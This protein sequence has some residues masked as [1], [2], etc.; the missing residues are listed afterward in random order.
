MTRLAIA[1]VCIPL[2][3]QIAATGL[4][5]SLD[6]PNHV[7]RLAYFATQLGLGTGLPR[8]SPELVF[9]LGYPLF[10]YYAPL[11]YYLGS[12]IMAFGVEAV[13]AFR[14]V[15]VGV[16]VLAGL[17]MFQLAVDFLRP[18]DEGPDPLGPAI[19]SATAYVFAPYFVVNLYVRVA[20]AELFAMALLPWVLWSFRRLVRDAQPA[21]AWPWAVL[22][23]TLLVF[24][25]SITIL[26]APTVIAAYLVVLLSHQPRRWSWVATA[27]VAAAGL[28]AGLWLPLAL[29]RG[30]VSTG[31]LA[32]SREWLDL[33][34]LAGWDQLNPFWPYRYHLNSPFQMGVFQVGL[35]VAG[36]LALKTKT[37]EARYLAW[38]AL[39]AWVLQWEVLRPL[40][41]TSDIWTIIQF[42]WRLNLL[43]SLS[44]A[45]LTGA[46]GQR[47]AGR[48]WAA[49][50]TSGLVLW[51]VIS[52]LPVVPFVS[53][54]RESQTH[55][56][57]ANIALYESATTQIGLSANVRNVNSDFIPRWVDL[58]R[59]LFA[60]AAAEPD[61]VQPEAI[62]VLTGSVGVMA[63]EVD[64]DSPVRIRSA[65]FYFPGWTATT[66]QGGALSVSAEPGTGWLAVD[67]PAGVTRVTLAYTG[68]DAQ[69]WAGWFSVFTAAVLVLLAAW[70]R[71]GW[72][73]W[74]TPAA[75]A[76]GF[77][78]QTSMPTPLPSPVEP[79]GKAVAMYG[80]EALGFQ[81]AQRQD[82]LEVTAYWFVRMPAPD[83]ELTWQVLDATERV[84]V[85]TRARP[86][87]DVGRADSWMTNSI[88]D[89]RQLLA[90]PGGL[91]A[92]SYRLR[93][94]GQPVV[95]GEGGR[96]CLAMHELGVFHLVGTRPAVPAGE[97]LATFG[98]DLTLEQVALSTATGARDQDP[99]R[100]VVAAGQ[101]LW[102]RLTWRALRQLEAEELHGFVQLL[103]PQGQRVASMDDRLGPLYLPQRLWG[104][105]RPYADEYEL[106]IPADLASGLYT[107]LIGVYTSPDD[108]A[109]LPVNGPGQSVDGYRLEPIKI[110]RRTLANP[111]AI[112]S[113]VYGSTAQLIG[114][115]LDPETAT[116]APGA[117]LTLRVYYR[118]VRASDRDLTQFV[119][120]YDPALGLVAQSDHRPTDGLNPTS[121]WIPGEVIVDTVVLKVNDDAPGGTYSLLVGLYDP[122]DGR[123][124]PALGRDGARWPDDAA[125]LTSITVLP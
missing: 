56:G 41:H 38:L 25:H 91:P 77:A 109:R 121:T 50:A 86:W 36:F 52:Y 33:N 93:V 31:S 37:R 67:V 12:A 53:F 103:D 99:G 85:E 22:T 43:T 4:P 123:R 30:F 113:D 17:G 95:D 83:L 124:V 120:L 28:T 90:L 11:G 35:G 73:W 118:A 110:L 32:I 39:L 46:V 13:T 107:P 1:V 15:L 71:L 54:L 72:G 70:R 119:H 42:P 117:T 97:I 57:P 26:V 89:D 19:L 112:R 111:R 21:R 80:I 84:V 47:W 105:D 82:D 60:P 10:N 66:A 114:F 102:A 100:L 16:S 122:A 7:M 62:R 5:F 98:T 96:A 20:V 29:E 106:T 108:P 78:W 44:L 45:L 63:F 55:L 59:G 69:R 18:G 88:V 65:T 2:T 14:I 6:A 79:P 49:L 115:D 92:G 101:R 3:W 76:A 64:S 9:G 24:A 27:L 51:I 58:S 104:L 34:F 74:A 87:Y 23:L 61:E 8:W 75:L 68:T 48:Q 81:T 40:W 125:A 94:C 116:V